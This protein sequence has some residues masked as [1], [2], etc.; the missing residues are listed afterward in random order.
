MNN[1]KS[2]FSHVALVA[3]LATSGAPGAYAYS[4]Q[5]QQVGNVTYVTGGIGDEERDALKAVKNDYNLSILSAARSGA[6]VG[7]TRVVILDRNGQKLVDTYADPIFYAQ[8][9]PGRYVVEGE[10]EGQSHKQNITIAGNKPAHVAFT[11]K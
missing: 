11:W 1:C 7:E 5:P 10:S 6:Y 4:L 8:L 9:P 2:Y 3:M